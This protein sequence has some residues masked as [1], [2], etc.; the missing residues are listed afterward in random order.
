MFGGNG[1]VAEDNEG[2][3][4]ALWNKTPGVWPD[5]LA[6]HQIT[7]FL[8]RLKRDIGIPIS[9]IVFRGL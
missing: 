9:C 8:K 4:T 3:A 2:L 6:E 5:L 1:F 7:R